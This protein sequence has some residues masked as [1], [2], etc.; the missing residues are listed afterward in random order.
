MKNKI[1]LNKEKLFYI[2][3]F[4]FCAFLLFYKLYNIMF[5]VHDDMRIYTLV[6]N[7]EFSMML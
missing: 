2:I 3:C 6:R 4:G 1:V 5:A 7:G